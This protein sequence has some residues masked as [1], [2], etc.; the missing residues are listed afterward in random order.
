[1]GKIGVTGFAL[2]GVR[3]AAAFVAAAVSFYLLERPFLRIKDRL[4]RRGGGE[5]GRSVLVGAGR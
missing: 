3:F 2:L 1:M 4:A 5:A